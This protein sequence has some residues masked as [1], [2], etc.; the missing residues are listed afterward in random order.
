MIGERQLEYDGNGMGCKR[1]LT[2][3]VQRAC[4]SAGFQVHYRSQG[5]CVSFRCASY[6][7]FRKARAK[8]NMTSSETHASNDHGSTLEP[9]RF[10]FS[11][12]WQA[13]E[14]R[15]AF[16]GGHGYSV[17]SSSV[18]RRMATL[19]KSDAPNSVMAHCQIGCPNEAICLPCGTGRSE[20]SDEQ[21]P[22]DFH[23]LD[24]TA[25]PR[26]GGAGIVQN[27]SATKGRPES[28]TSATAFGSEAVDNRKRTA[29]WEALDSNEAASESGAWS[30][31]DA[32]FGRTSKENTC[33]TS[34]EEQRHRAIPQV[35]TKYYRPELTR[36]DVIVDLGDDDS[37]EDDKDSIA[38]SDLFVAPA[39]DVNASAFIRP[40]DHSGG[41]PEDDCLSDIYSVS[42]ESVSTEQLPLD[43]EAWPFDM[44]L[45]EAIK[46]LD[47]R[48]LRGM[49]PVSQ[50][51]TCNDSMGTEAERTTLTRFDRK[52]LYKS[53][54]GMVNAAQENPRAA[55]YLK[56]CLSQ[57]SHGTRAIA[58]WD[59]QH[60]GDE[61]EAPEVDTMEF[62]C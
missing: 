45:D 43:K 13:D 46:I 35:P 58:A 25:R 40:R 11:L 42:S 56:L 6:D 52:E 9:C 10:Q 34:E 54:V 49:V 4:Q 15:W 23:A 20:S 24:R 22:S 59:R 31:D 53:F 61:T 2:Q 5:D 38:E 18:C 50:N 16:Q 27:G 7:K 29:S 30:H 33:S 32:S 41:A 3:L 14:L 12:R 26:S 28:Y 36:E 48:P 21:S 1:A 47:A 19:D 17:H 39:L 37:S 57:C 51:D 44:H 8:L 60:N 62:E 55:D